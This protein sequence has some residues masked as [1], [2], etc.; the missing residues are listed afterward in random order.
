MPIPHR[1]KV[2]IRKLQRSQTTRSVNF[3]L[4]IRRRSLQLIGVNQSGRKRVKES[5]QLERRVGRLYSSIHVHQS[6]LRIKTRKTK[7]IWSDKWNLVRQP[8]REMVSWFW[9]TIIKSPLRGFVPHKHP[10]RFI[11]P[12]KIDPIFLEAKEVFDTPI[13]QL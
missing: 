10:M 4:P 13:M 2:K 7:W 12:I 3:V 9:T 5:A 8:K 11:S 1:E 6:A